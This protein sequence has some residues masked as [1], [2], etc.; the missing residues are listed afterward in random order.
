MEPS[1]QSQGL[2]GGKH[3][4]CPAQAIFANPHIP[5]SIS[6]SLPHSLI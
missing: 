5:Q 4:Q 6:H 1:H 3:P 2:A